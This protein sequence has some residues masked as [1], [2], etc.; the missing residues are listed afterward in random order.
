[1]AAIRHCS[2]C[3]RE[4]ETGH[5]FCQ[6]R[7]ENGSLKQENILCAIATDYLYDKPVIH[8]RENAKV[9]SVG[10]WGCNLR[11]LGCQNAGL[12][13]SVTG[14]NLGS[15]EIKPRE[16]V[17]IA[18]KNECK[19]ICYT[20]NEPAI[21]LETVEKISS[22]ARERNLFNVFVT[23]SS[24]TERSVKKISPYIDAVAADIKSLKD[25]FYYKYCGATGIP[26]VAP[27]ILKCIRAFSESGLH[28]EVRTNI[29]PGA[30]DQEEN[31]HGIASWIRDNL[32]YTTPWHITRFFP[33]YKL[34]HIGQT[35]EVSMLRAQQIGIIEGLKYV[36]TFL[37]KGCDCA[38]ESDLVAIC[39]A[40]EI[41]DC[42]KNKSR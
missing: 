3:I 41:H 8:F 29:I 27:K 36:H 16:I 28:V 38:K 37:D 11:C 17:D 42:C 39:E 10:S 33:A 26:D 21:L 7:N 40:N 35:P 23:N 18:L 24:L 34:S 5:S 31:Y 25:D 32:G 22:I 14:E 15:V 1:M 30:N 13:W 4:C 6:R 20:F 19:G 2:V 9:L 12:S